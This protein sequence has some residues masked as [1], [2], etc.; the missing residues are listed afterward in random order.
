MGMNQPLKKSSQIEFIELNDKFN[1]FKFIN[2]Y[3]IK[4]ER[5]RCMEIIKHKSND[6][7]KVNVK[8]RLDTNT[9]PDLEK[10]VLEDLDGI[11]RLECDLE[12]LGYISSAGLRV[13]LL[14][15]K[16]MSSKKG[17]LKI[18]HPCDEVMEVFDMTG[19]STFL[20]IEE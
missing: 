19:F 10:S 9:A 2:T 18:L 15:H 7:L 12:E 1:D 4:N 16:T 14:L 6:T 17:T 8:G 3:N 5:G 13:I 20:N 11:N